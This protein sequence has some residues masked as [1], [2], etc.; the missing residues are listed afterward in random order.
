MMSSIDIL[1]AL[2]VGLHHARSRRQDGEPGY[3]VAIT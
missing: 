2:V 3:L 1:A